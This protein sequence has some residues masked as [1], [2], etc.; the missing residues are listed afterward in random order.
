MTIFEAIRKDHDIQRDLLEIL[1]TTTGESKGRQELFEK[2]KKELSV[3]ADA[4]ERH[5]YKPLISSEM[6]QD[7]ARHGIA[8]H[9]E[10]DELVEKLENTEFSSSSWLKIAKDLKEKVEHHL[11]DE[12]QKFF[13]LSGKVLSEEQKKELAKDYSTYVKEHR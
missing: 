3:H 12:E 10:I 11:E 13:Q 5:Y 6:M 7:K 9:H 1:V 4:E 2:L 8:E